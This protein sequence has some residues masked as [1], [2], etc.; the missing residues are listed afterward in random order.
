MEPGALTIAVAGL[1]CKDLSSMG[2]LKSF[3]GLSCP[4]FL[5]F[6]FEARATKPHV[7]IVE[8]VV[9]FFKSGGCFDKLV[10]LLRD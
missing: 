1:V 6:I 9:G 10:E 8:E 4:S 7:I 3:V 5:S 2:S